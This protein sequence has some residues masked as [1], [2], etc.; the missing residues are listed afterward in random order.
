MSGSTRGCSAGRAR[1]ATPVCRRPD[2]GRSHRPVARPT[3]SCRSCPT[4]RSKWPGP[5]P[6][7]GVWT[8]VPADVGGT[9]LT[10]AASGTCAFAT[11]RPRPRSRRYAIAAGRCSSAR[12]R[13][14]DRLSVTRTRDAAAWASARLVVSTLGRPIAEIR[15]SARI[16]SP[17]RQRVR[18]RPAFMAAHALRTAAGGTA[19]KGRKLWLRG[20][21]FVAVRSKT[22]D[23]RAVGNAACA[24]ES[25]RL[26][27]GGSVSD[28]VRRPPLPLR[29]GVLPGR[30]PGGD[31][32]HGAGAGRGV[33]STAA[34]PPA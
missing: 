17:V 15:P 25:A 26:L 4:A 6:R 21:W 27:P 28:R 19:A 16:T 7:H 2:R 33:V 18:R 8:I 5:E 30:R 11:P 24:A 10:P 32:R 9:A 14:A 13:R 29:R 3:W 23:G 1:C 31:L 20:E 34:R 12:R 22:A